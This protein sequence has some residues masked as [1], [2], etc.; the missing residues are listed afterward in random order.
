MRRAAL[1]VLSF[2]TYHLSVGHA[3]AQQLWYDKPAATWTQALPLGNGTMGAMV[4]GTPAVEHIQLNEETLWAGR[5]NQVLNPEAREYL[6]QVRQL[7]FEGR[8]REA[9]E[10][11]DEKVMPL[12]AGK[13]CGMPFQPFGDVYIAQPG[14]TAYSDYERL[15]DLNEASH[16]VRYTVDGVQFE[17]ETL[18]PLGSKVLAVHF[19]ASQPGKVTF[20]ASMQTPHDY[21]LVGNENGA[22]YLHGVTG[23]HEGVKSLV[24][25]MG[26]MAVQTDGGTVSV[27]DGQLS[28]VGA[29]KATLYI[30]VGSNVKNYNDVSGDEQ[31]QSRQRLIE[32][33]ALG[34]DS[35]KARHHQ[36]YHHYF[37]R[38]KLSLPTPL[39]STFFQYGRYL[40]ICS[41]QPD[42]INPANL[43]GLWNDRMWPSWDS[44]YTTN[45][46]LEMNYWPAE[47][48]NLT[49]LN[50]PLFRLINE[51]SE[52]GR[53]TARD[54]YGADGWV[55]HHNTDQWR[56]TG[57][58][59]HAATG[60]WPMGGAW[61]CRHLWE[62]Y[63]F[64]GDREFLQKAFP[65]M[66]D[67]ARFYSQ[68][69]VE[70]SSHLSPL[71][72]RPY[73]VICPG[74]S[75][76]HGG[77]GHGSSLDAG[78]TMDNQLVTE[79]YNEVLM[80]AERLRVDS[81]EFRDVSSDVKGNVA[82][83]LTLNSQLL[84]TLRQQ[85]PLL[86]PM[87]IGR[88]GQL[89]EW[90]DDVDDPQDDHRHSSHLYGLFPSNQISPY[91]TPELWQAAKTSLEAR[92]D[93]STGWS[94]AWKVCSW[95]RL[96]DG[97]HAYKLICDQLTL[98]PD[99]FL[100]IGTTKQRGGTYPNLFDAHPPF[101]IDGNFGC[102]AGIAEM[103]LQSHDGFVF[104]LPALPSAWPEGSVSGLKARGGF[105]VD[106]QWKDGRLQH[107][108]IR[109]ALGGV[110][111]L[112]SYV[113]LKGKG[114]RR[115]RDDHPN[116]ALPRTYLYDLPTQPAGEYQIQ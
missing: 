86:P 111:R 108:V 114:L 21:P 85:L 40:L 112:R 66:A 10:L 87:Q 38:V 32:A 8:Y 97:D 9:Q 14:H 45:I 70:D 20:T 17:R 15:L 79:L 102:T 76:E 50:G 62:H 28:V 115:V 19:T 1:I 51:V 95:A 72:S 11:A 103:L 63:L 46:N 77:P 43:Q 93:V 109:S 84:D 37:D 2:I 23:K 92:G 39:V 113:P 64:T 61:L 74:E 89:Q 90:L 69:L 94:M 60:L 26:L 105:E 98:T 24:R 3:V 67:A 22:V 53:Q 99:T 56:I 54:M 16:F 52:T 29:D 58:V 110:C 106:M 83:L 18:A 80:A 68:I 44:K 101:Q 57:P 65:V 31:L 47:V 36:I 91:R 6:P 107:A 25:F 71:T 78:V 41:S 81:L 5:P 116:A 27:A 42:D 100:I 49:E 30:T 59:D 4:Y 33:M 88:W 82:Q 13:N 35:L 75:P 73:L 96:L 7:I 12:G 34:Y 48:C 55:L 104:L